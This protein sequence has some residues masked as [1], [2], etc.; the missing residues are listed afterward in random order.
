MKKKLLEFIFFVVL[1]TVMVMSLNMAVADSTAMDIKPVEL[2][3]Y[4]FLIVLTAAI[5]I[6]LPITLLAAAAILVGG[7]LYAYVYELVIP[8]DVINYFGSFFRW[9]PQYVIG[10]ESFQMDFSLLFA[11]LYIVL[12]TLVITLIVMNR[13]G[14]GFLIALGT[15]AFAF[16]WFIYVSKA[17]LYLFT[18]LFA[19][20]ILYS[21][22]VYDRKKSEWISAESKIDHF[23]EIK[24]VFNSLIIVLVSITI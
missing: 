14:Y 20:L 1:I 2:L 18:Y 15:G 16:F 22:N 23:I 4:T 7:G 8:I 21:Y 17:R 12:V 11:I 9:L 19:A 13:K 10:Y 6:R 5:L 24:W 3:K